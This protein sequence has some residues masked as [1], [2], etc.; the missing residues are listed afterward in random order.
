MR[1]VFESDAGYGKEVGQPRFD[2]AEGGVFLLGGVLAFAFFAQVI[3]SGLSH[4]GGL[5]L[6][7][8]DGFGRYFELCKR[9]SYCRSEGDDAVEVFGFFESRG[10]GIGI[11]PY[12]AEL[13]DNGRVAPE[14]YALTTSNLCE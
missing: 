1:I 4:Q 6:G 5:L 8:G 11:T 14:T 12:D 13:L 7:L 9:G 10:E 2:G 3:G